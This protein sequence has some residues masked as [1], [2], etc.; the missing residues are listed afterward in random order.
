LGDAGA[1]IGMKGFGASAP[2]ETLY[3]EFG[4]TVEAVTAAAPRN[5][6]R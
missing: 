2:A 4:I 5:V 3:Q 1:F 6:T